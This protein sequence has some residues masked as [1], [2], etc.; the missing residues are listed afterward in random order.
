[1]STTSYS[2]ASFDFRDLKGR[3]AIEHVLADLGLLTGFSRRGDKLVGPCPLHRG[4]SNTAFVVTRSRNLWYCFTRCRGGGDV[5]DL[6]RR[7]RGY[8]YQY[9][10]RYLADLSGVAPPPA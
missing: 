8:S 10:A 6:V 4:D 9:T 3:V 2:R 5:I 7:L 1:M